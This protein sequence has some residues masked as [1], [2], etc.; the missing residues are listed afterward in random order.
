M[1]LQKRRAVAYIAGRLVTGTTSG[2]VYD[3]TAQARFKLYGDVSPGFVQVYDGD[4]F[5]YIIGGATPAGLSIF[6][7][8]TRQHIQLKISDNDFY[9]FDYE[10]G[11]YFSGEV[12][13]STV[14]FFDF[15][16]AKTYRYAV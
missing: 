6:D 10:T 16:D 1:N 9:G 11:A 5:S 12:N 13:K 4:R 15:Q 14:S 2:G 8:Y 7:Y 3:Y